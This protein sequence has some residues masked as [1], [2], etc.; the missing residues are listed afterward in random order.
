ML[1]RL[2]YCTAFIDGRINRDGRLRQDIYVRALREH[3]AIDE[4]EEGKFMARVRSGLMATR[5]A[6]G[7]PII[8]KAQWPVV[9]RDNQRPAGW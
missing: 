6:D 9:V 7:R 5:D 1:K 4:L 3:G 2:V 8:T